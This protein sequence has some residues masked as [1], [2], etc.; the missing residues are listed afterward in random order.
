MTA[1]TATDSLEA[2]D[3][4]LELV[5]EER[6]HKGYRPRASWWVR[7]HCMTVAL[8]DS[9]V[10]WYLRHERPGMPW[11]CNIHFVLWHNLKVLGPIN[12]P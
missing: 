4:D 1:A 11:R 2:L 7:M 9:C 10:E 5:C 8:C 6:V 12:A 3:F